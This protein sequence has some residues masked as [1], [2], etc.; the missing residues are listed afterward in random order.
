MD[1]GETFLGDL[2]HR[3][4]DPRPL[5]LT[6]WLRHIGWGDHGDQFAD[7]ES[8]GLSSVKVVGQY[9]LQNV[10]PTIGAEIQKTRQALVIQNDIAYRH[11]PITIVAAIT[12]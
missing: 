3:L 5:L 4:G 8:L 6:G 11:S 12:A 2:P 7:V 10:D 9:G 1:N